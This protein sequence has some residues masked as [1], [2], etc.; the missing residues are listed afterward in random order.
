MIATHIFV[1]DGQNWLDR[2]RRCKQIIGEH[3]EICSMPEHGRVHKVPDTSKQQAEHRR[4]A[5]ESETDQ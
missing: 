2:I 5:G 1:N 4:R 3:G